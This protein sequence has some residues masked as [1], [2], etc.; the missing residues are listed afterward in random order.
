M[1]IVAKINNSSS[2]EMTPKFSL[3]QDVVFRANGNTK[4]ES[5]VIQ[6]VVDPCIKAQWQKDIR[7]AMQIPRDQRP[8]IQNCEIISVEYHLKVSNGCQMFYCCSIFKLQPNVLMRLSCF[9][10]SGV[11]GHQLCFRSRDHIPSSHYSSRLGAW[12]GCG[13]LPSWG[14]WGPEQ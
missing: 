5:H 8:S 4:H 14:C 6:K 3:I 12:C 7:C 13:S 2:S 11:S 1:V 9:F 10:F